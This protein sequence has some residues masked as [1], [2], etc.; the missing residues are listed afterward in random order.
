MQKKGVDK[1]N[2]T[3]VGQRERVL[4]S[5]LITSKE[6]HDPRAPLRTNSQAQIKK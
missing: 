1:K 3:N 6:L 2:N 4:G 5:G